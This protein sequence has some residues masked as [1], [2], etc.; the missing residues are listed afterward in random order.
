M[1]GQ[2]Q[3]EPHVPSTQ[4]PRAA[5]IG[6]QVEPV[7]EKTAGKTAVVA[8]KWVIAKVSEGGKAVVKQL[9]RKERD[10]L[11]APHCELPG[12]HAS[13]TQRFINV[14][15]S[16]K[17]RLG[18]H[19][20]DGKLTK[21]SE[22]PPTPEDAQLALT[23]KFG[24]S[25][26]SCINLQNEIIDLSEQ[27]DRAPEEE[28]SLLDPAI[29]VLQKK[30]SESRE[31]L[32][33]EIKETY[34][35]LRAQKE[36]IFSLVEK[37]AEGSGAS[38]GGPKILMSLFRE[39]ESDAK[40]DLT[41]ELGGAYERIL[42]DQN[43]IRNSNQQLDLL[44]DAPDSSDK[45]EKTAILHTAISKAENAIRTNT[46][47]L[48]TALQTK[49]LEQLTEI[50]EAAHI[51]GDTRLVALV[52]T[53]KEK[54]EKIEATKA[55]KVEL[56]D[57]YA[58]V[59]GERVVTKGYK[60]ALKELPNT[61]E[62]KSEIERLSNK[63]KR[64]EDA[65]VESLRSLLQTKTPEELTR[66]GENAQKAGDVVLVKLAKNQKEKIEAK[67][68]LIKA[69]GNAYTQLL[70]EQ[71]YI[72]NV[73]NNLKELPDTPENKDEIEKLQN[74]I[75]ESE[76]TIKTKTDVIKFSL[77]KKSPEEREKIRM[78]A[79]T[80]GDTLITGM[81]RSITQ[82]DAREALQ[83]EFGD[84]Y[85]QIVAAQTL[86][87]NHKSNLDEIQKSQS[88]DK[89]SKKAHLEGLIKREEATIARLTESLLDGKNIQER[90]E[91]YGLVQM[92]GDEL[93]MGIVKA[94]NI[95][96][97]LRT[98]L[99]DPTH[100]NHRALIEDSFAI[101]DS[102]VVATAIRKELEDI[103]KNPNAEDRL[104]TVL[105][106][107][108]QWVE[109]T[110]RLPGF[111]GTNDEAGKPKLSVAQEELM[112]I[113]HKLHDFQELSK[114]PEISE[115]IHAAGDVISLNLFPK[116][117]AMR[118]PSYD[119]AKDIGPELEKVR[120][121]NISRAENPDAVKTAAQQEYDTLVGAAAR[122]FTNMQVALLKQ[123]RP[124]DLI[125]TSEDKMVGKTEAGKVF[126]DLAN[127][128]A[129]FVAL[130]ILSEKDSSKRANLENFFLDVAEQALKA[131][132]LATSHA[133]FSAFADTSIE[134]LPEFQGK[135]LMRD[136]YNSLQSLFDPGDTNNK[137]Y[138]AKV[139]AIGDRPY[140]P[141][142]VVATKAMKFTKENPNFT[143]GKLDDFVLRAHHKQIHDVLRAAENFEEGAPATNIVADVLQSPSMP[144]S[145]E[146]RYALSYEI[147]PRGSSASKSKK[148][149]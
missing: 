108:T 135:S 128:T 67:K 25:Y 3:F 73:Q 106:F 65:N 99:A 113:T 59:L 119:Q 39:I 107:T 71:S 9:S 91:I 34:S 14:I 15:N 94:Q 100:P 64:L 13:L 125:L 83:H 121:G 42:L 129:A 77:I 40:T 87:K 92:A 49:T 57:A 145:N 66:I 53:Q 84:N 138:Y 33:S 48:R 139:S 31:T 149:S 110:N 123:V 44:K 127:K 148:G 109:Y 82:K 143:K 75:S 4:T 104:L 141:L 29:N 17:I 80:I 146:R 90:A 47:S 22:R 105:N 18:L 72:R 120:D 101:A 21:S 61:P 10:S 37:A 36:M 76:A 78:Y 96:A 102:G 144:E 74:W 11:S 114:F 51:I 45:Q 69:L 124:S 147:L 95:E 60:E 55:L 1:S 88:P 103:E 140:V 134:R 79:E 32:K 118:S 116:E 46:E 5:H 86:L 27:R 85:K 26:E 58:T 136:R 122:D 7:V 52:K 2:A 24:K 12:A 54:T 16:T 35:P 81:T 126:T 70:H 98:I 43:L 137:N 63:I 50:N 142:M 117:V 23:A 56:G 133:I 111:Q 131:N 8:A 38:T 19:R 115:A 89:S 30:L 28:K 41:K 62:N 112:K 93:L 97:G 6:D 20:E 130:K 132:D 68:D